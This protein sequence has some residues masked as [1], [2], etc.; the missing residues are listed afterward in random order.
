[1]IAE[2]VLKKVSGLAISILLL[3]AV[4]HVYGAVIYHSH[5]R[6]HTVFVALPV[7][8]VLWQ[9]HRM[10]LQR[11]RLWV[12]RI[13][14]MLIWI[15]PVLLIGLYEGVYNHLLKDILYYAG[16]SPEAFDRM[17][18]PPLYEK[19]NDLFFEI[20]GVLQGVLYFP[21]QWMLLSQGKKW[22]TT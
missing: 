12:R 4:H 20:T 9:L 11:D 7:A 10:L 15:I 14:L 5:W 1:M 22:N 13:Y 2:K 16:I 18:P 6:L 21:L 19:P 3:T 8:L 17:F